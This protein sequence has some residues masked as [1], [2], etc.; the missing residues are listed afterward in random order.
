MSEKIL[1]L[2]VLIDAENTSAK[3]IDVL[4]E[5]IAKIGEAGVR[6]IYGDFSGSRLN[7]WSSVLQNYAIVPQQQF[8][9]TIGK[10]S[11]DIALVIDA[12]DLMHRNIFDGFCLVSSDS[13]FTRLTSRIREEGLLVVGFGKENTPESFVKACSRF[14]YLENLIEKDKE[15]EEHKIIKKS[16]S[17][18]IPL[19]RKI[20]KQKEEDLVSLGEIGTQIRAVF[21]EFDT[22][23]FGFSKLSELV[24]ST[25]IFYLK[26]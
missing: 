6:R 20:I 14:I 10:N 16:P 22:R 8:A 1:R 25:K 4:F 23:S 17:S 5:E 9:Y 21:P 7:S 18:I 13:D 15:I 19:I 24:E 3:I 2:A 11:S 12:M 26:K